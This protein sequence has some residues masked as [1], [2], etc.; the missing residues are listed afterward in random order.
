MIE[1]GGWSDGREE[2]GEF[3]KEKERGGRGERGKEER[4]GQSLDGEMEA[5]QE[6]YIFFRIL[7]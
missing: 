6:R 4:K 5:G 1:G 7:L 2:R 3:V